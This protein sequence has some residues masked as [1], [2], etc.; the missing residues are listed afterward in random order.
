MSGIPVTPERTAA[1]QSVL[2]DGTGTTQPPAQPAPSDDVALLVRGQTFSGW[3]SV[4]I[5]RCLD[6]MPNDFEI[7]AT[8]ISPEQ[9]QGFFCVPGDAI[10]LTVG[11]ELILTGY[12]D[13]YAPSVTPDSHT[14][15]V[16]GRSRSQDLVDC[17]ITDAEGM[18]DAAG[19]F[20]QLATRLAAPFNIDI[21]NQ[22]TTT[23]KPLPQFQMMLTDTPFSVLDRASRYLGLIMYDDVDGNVIVGSLSDQRAG[24]D[25][26][27]G[28]NVESVACEFS[29]DQRFSDYWAFRMP[30]FNPG[31]SSISHQQLSAGHFQ[32]TA[33]PRHR[34]KAI[35]AAFVGIDNQSFAAQEAAWQCGRRYGRSWSA[36]IVT[37]TWR[38][39]AGQLWKPNTLIGLDLPQLSIRPG[40]RVTWCIGM[41][42]YI[43]GEGGT[44][45]E[46]LIMPQEAFMPE[47]T[48]LAPFNTNE[49]QDQGS[50][51]TAATTPEGGTQGTPA[52]AQNTQ[53]FAGVPGLPGT[54]S[55]PPAVRGPNPGI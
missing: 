51:N 40:L 1:I 10:E 46:L 18:Q 52:P 41:V 55:G 49:L 38:D 6:R 39:G 15:R 47:P 29:M 24:S 11:S 45:C 22:A 44:T 7:E 43:R 12:I 30:Y 4:R 9:P 8:E 19:D 54:P 2:N 5:S 13:R 3:T 16:T 32:D 27:L 36:R 20:F 35:V 42:T 23:P 48:I 37:S 50:G 17:N 26:V 34:P 31:D 53:G 21:K 14:I 28:L 33:V 25:M